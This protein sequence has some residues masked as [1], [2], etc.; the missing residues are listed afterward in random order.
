MAFGHGPHQC[1]GSQLARLEMRIAYTA[2]LRRFPGLRL[3]VPHEE[4][5]L[6]DDMVIHGTHRLPIAW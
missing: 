4:V 1:L 5:P 6:R 2:L 3:A